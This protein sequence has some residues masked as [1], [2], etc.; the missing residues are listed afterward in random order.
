MTRRLSFL[1][2]ALLVVGFTALPAIGS[3]LD[4]DLERVRE[5]ISQ[6]RGQISSVAAERSATARSVLA[7]ADA[8]D[9]AEREVTAASAELNL[10][11]VALDQRNADLS[12]V[13]AELAD[14]LE[15][16]AD[17]RDARDAARGE[18]EG[19][20]LRAYMGGGPAQ[21]S[22]A[23]NAAAV[24]DISVGVMY[25]DVLT[26]FSSEAADRYADLAVAEETQQEEVR[27][28]EAIVTADVAELQGLGLRLGQLQ[29]DLL[30]RRGELALAYQE[31]KEL[32]DE[33]D[34][35]I[36]HFEGELTAL[37][38]EESSIRSAIAAASAP[39]VSA[40]SVSS[41]GFVRPVPGAVSSGFGMRVHPIT[42]QNRMHNGLDMNAA[43]GDPI[44]AVRSGTVILAGVKGGYGNTI[45]I[46]HGGGMVTL[47]AHQSRFGSSVGDRVAA[48][49]VI[50]YIGSTGLST[51]PHLHFEVRINGNPVDPARYL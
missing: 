44:R 12:A 11:R 47:Y 18:A 5:R 6:V 36:E 46:D 23:F 42:G 34:G 22:I 15:V 33:L 40:P 7:A 39:A 25:L 2:L 17:I 50:G 4:S 8:L 49:E 14:R 41:S 13:R 30:E 37:A 35:E 16:L 31:Q 3:D 9:D 51:G 38:R 21:P 19:W 29:G 20:A 27:R 43:H 45:M 10:V 26:E 32:L 24:A 28:I 48:G 1:A